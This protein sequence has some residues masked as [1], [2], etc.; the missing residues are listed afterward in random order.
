MVLVSFFVE[1]V[2]VHSIRILVVKDKTTKLTTTLRLSELNIGSIILYARKLGH[3]ASVGANDSGRACCGLKVCNRIT[4]S[5]LSVT[6]SLSTNNSVRNS[7]TLTRTT[8]STHKF[9]GLYGLN[10]TFP[11]SK[12][13]RCVKCGASRSPENETADIK[14]CASHSVYVTLTHRIREH[15][16]RVYRSILYTHLLTRAGT[17]SRFKI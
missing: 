2:V 6:H 14:P 12:F 16:I 13:K 7:V 5:P 10:I 8:L 1:Y 9:F 4:S 11:Y 17:D 3:N 15:K